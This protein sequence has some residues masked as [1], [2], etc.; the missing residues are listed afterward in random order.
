VNAVETGKCNP[1][2][3]LAFK[4]ARLFERA[5]EDIFDDAPET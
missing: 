2:L 5:I 4:L 3:S 1:R